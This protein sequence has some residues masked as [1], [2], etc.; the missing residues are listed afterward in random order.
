[1]TSGYVVSICS[2]LLMILKTR[3]LRIPGLYVLG[4]CSTDI[5]KSLKHFLF[6]TNELLSQLQ[7]LK[8]I[9]KTVMLTILET[10]LC[11]LISYVHVGSYKI[12]V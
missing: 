8:G 12:I 11:A 1:M 3:T 2:Q 5:M 7:H 6:D 10:V 4:S 9:L